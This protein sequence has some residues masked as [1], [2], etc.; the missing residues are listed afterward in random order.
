MLRRSQ[1]IIVHANV[2]KEE[3]CRDWRVPEER[4]HVLPIGDLGTLYLKADQD[5]SLT[6]RRE[7]TGLDVLS[8]ISDNFSANLQRV[9]S[10]LLL[11][12]G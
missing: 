12:A 1:A 4:V 6:S 2:L 11:V 8:P 10:S 9:S 7:S 5:R 3:L